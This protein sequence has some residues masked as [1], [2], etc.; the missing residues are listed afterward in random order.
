MADNDNIQTLLKEYHRNVKNQINSMR[1]NYCEILK[2]SEQNINE[3]EESVKNLKSNKE[4]GIPGNLMSNNQSSL[5]SSNNKNNKFNNQ[6]NAKNVSNMPD[7]EIQSKT[8]EIIRST[9]SLLNLTSDLKTLVIVSDLTSEHVNKTES[10]N[11]LCNRNKII[12]DLFVKSF[13]SR[14]T[15]RN[16]WA[17]F[18]L[19]FFESKIDE[20]RCFG[21]F[22]KFHFLALVT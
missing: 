3:A 2:L 16:F 10:N 17:K 12:K 8:N 4:N 15:F 14:K 21:I 1:S 20:F 9:N 5:S 13:V 11:A 19:K 22:M 7:L 18:F 6:K